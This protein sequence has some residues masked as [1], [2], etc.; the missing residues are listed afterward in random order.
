MTRVLLMLSVFAVGCSEDSSPAKPD[1]ESAKPAIQAPTITPEVKTVAEPNPAPADVPQL[2]I[3]VAQLPEP[4]DELS[5]PA[6]PLE[7]QRDKTRFALLEEKDRTELSHLAEQI[8]A[9]TYEDVDLDLLFQHLALFN[10]PK[11]RKWLIGFSDRVGGSQLV[12]ILGPMD[13]EQSERIKIALIQLNGEEIRDV[14]LIA[15]KMR[16]S[17]AD[18]LAPGE[19]EFVNQHLVVFG[20]E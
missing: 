3:P 1:P 20:L 9:G 12:E 7:T 10:R 17:G 15:R 18:S 5:S 19:R 2:E 16:D 6:L 4:P 11:V 8:D 13:A 14:L